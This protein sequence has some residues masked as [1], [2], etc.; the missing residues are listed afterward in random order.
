MKDGK[1]SE[2]EYFLREQE[3]A[4]YTIDSS[5]ATLLHYAAQ[6]HNATLVERFINSGYNIDALDDQGNTPL[7]FAVLAGDAI[8]DKTNDTLSIR[9]F[10]NTMQ[11]LLCEGAN[12]HMV[13]KNGDSV[14]PIVFR[15]SNTRFSSIVNMFLNK[16]KEE[17]PKN[18]QVIAR[19]LFA[20]DCP[21]TLSLRLGGL[22]LTKNMLELGTSIDS[23]DRITGRTALH[24]AVGSSDLTSVKFLL[25][26]N[27]NVNVA[28]HNKQTPLMN[29]NT[30]CDETSQM[31]DILKSLMEV[32]R[33]LDIKSMKKLLSSGKKMSLLALMERGGCDLSLRNEHDE[34]PIHFLARNPNPDVIAEV[35][36]GKRGFDVN[37]SDKCGNTPLMD[38]VMAGHTHA[39]EYLLSRKADPNITNKI[40]LSPLHCLFYS[41]S[42]IKDGHVEV[43]QLLL[44]DGAKVQCDTRRHTIFDLNLTDSYRR[45]VTPVLAHLAKLEADG[46]SVDRTIRV[47]ID[48]NDT[49]KSDFI[50]YQQQL[51]EM[52]MYTVYGLVTLYDLLIVSD[53][54]LKLYAKEAEFIY[55]FDAVMDNKCMRLYY[56]L[57][58]VKKR[59]D[60]AVRELEAENSSASVC[61]IM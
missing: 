38:A 47:C 16:V 8:T 51:E 36:R 56:Y 60:K 49:L 45:L 54:R 5:G 3:D 13:N 48:A 24:E 41:D 61:S 31:I 33:H 28:D 10:K 43:V 11:V 39:V 57:G 58:V 27:A 15:F 17:S 44:R 34:T 25:K 20:A 18:N 21:L 23:C 2:I 32:D 40:G 7:L 52:K 46:I 50:S 35:L 4:C 26:H 14:L 1:N 42:K 59:V 30:L 29:Y 37:L 6:Y 22:E 9:K 19:K 55:N 53:E 12:I